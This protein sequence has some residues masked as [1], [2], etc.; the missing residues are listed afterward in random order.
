MNEKT[1]KL[2]ARSIYCGCYKASLLC[3]GPGIKLGVIGLLEVYFLSKAS[4]INNSAEC[5]PNFDIF[6]VSFMSVFVLRLTDVLLLKQTQT[7]WRSLYQVG[8]L[9]TH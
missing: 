1:R 9:K 7:L 6:L 5:F 3:C 8:R 2:E 4:C